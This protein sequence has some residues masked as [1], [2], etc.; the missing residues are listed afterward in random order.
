VVEAGALYRATLEE[1]IALHEQIKANPQPVLEAVAV[2]PSAAPL[3][4]TLTVCAAG[5]APPAR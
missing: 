2:K 1:T 3:P 4:E 5:T